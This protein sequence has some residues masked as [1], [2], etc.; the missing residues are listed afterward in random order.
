MLLNKFAVQMRCKCGANRLLVNKIEGFGPR[1][2]ILEVPE[3]ALKEALVNAMVHRDYNERG[4][5]VLVEIYDDR[6]EI[7]NP[8]GLVSAIKKEEFGKKSIS[9]NPLLFSLFKAV[10]LVE[11]VGSGISRMRKAMKQAGLPAPKFEFTD[12]FTVT[13]RRPVSPQKTPQK[14]PQKPTELEQKILNLIKRKTTIT[15]L[16]ISRELKLSTNTVKEYLD[17]LK[18]K[19]YLE[20]VGGRKHGYW[21]IRGVQDG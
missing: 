4:A 12:F 18:E 16:E 14:T 2:E 17:R 11:K 8:G 13:F 10:D 21:R 3:A 19:G 7:T 20:R 5:E 1:K 15:R 6:V 9:R